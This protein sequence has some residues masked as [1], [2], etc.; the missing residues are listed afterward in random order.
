MLA[1]TYGVGSYQLEKGGS[2]S[3][4]ALGFLTFGA[5]SIW[6]LD[7]NRF[8]GRLGIND[9][10]LSSRKGAE[11]R[12]HCPSSNRTWSQRAGLADGGGCAVHGPATV[13]SLRQGSIY[14]AHNTCR[15]YMSTG[16][17][18]AYQC[19]HQLRKKSCN[20]RP[21]KSLAHMVR[22]PV[23]SSRLSVRPSVHLSPDPK[24]N[25]KQD[26]LC[27]FHSH[28]TYNETMERLAVS[29][30]HVPFRSTSDAN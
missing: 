29:R 27:S 12:Q 15:T 4:A 5:K 6:I 13:S 23:V 21:S 25:T 30:R 11:R 22:D 10:G 9:V 7:E 20:S 14:A 17:E 24:S 28:A 18:E 3:N 16:L 8:K 2:K 19:V 26:F 1:R